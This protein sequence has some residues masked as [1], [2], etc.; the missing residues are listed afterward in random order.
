M[1]AGAPARSCPLVTALLAA[2]TDG[3]GCSEPLRWVDG[4]VEAAGR[5]WS[6]GRPGDVPATGDWSC[7]GRSSLAVLRPDT[8]QVFVFG[9][10]AGP[11]RDVAAPLAARVEG[12]FALRPADLDGDGC[13][14]L[15]V[16][17]AGGPPV[18]VPVRAGG[19]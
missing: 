19:R 16:E 13:L 2:D 14:D 8:G 11:G 5:R 17:R 9:G 4:V 7:S 12:A 10:W 3:D 1:V 18:T 15:L 6:V